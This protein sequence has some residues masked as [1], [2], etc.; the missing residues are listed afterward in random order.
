MKD[1]DSLAGYLKLAGFAAPE[2]EHYF[3]MQEKRK[4]A[5]LEAA[6][7][8]NVYEARRRGEEYCQTNGSDHYIVPGVEPMDLIISLGY[9]EHFCLASIIKYAARYGEGG[10]VED[11]KKIADYAHILCGV[12]HA[13][14]KKKLYNG[15]LDN[16]DDVRSTISPEATAIAETEPGEEPG[17][18]ERARGCD[19]GSWHPYTEIK[20]WGEKNNDGY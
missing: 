8:P 20:V 18:L 10:N 7:P 3:E 4:Q 17:R 1:K 9:A 14:K 5:K 12:K 11:L 2:I 13:E 16:P 19:R 6:G 15:S